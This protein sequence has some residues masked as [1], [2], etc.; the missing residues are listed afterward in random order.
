MTTTRHT[1]SMRREAQQAMPG[2]RLVTIPSAGHTVLVEQPQAGTAAITDL[3]R[4]V[5]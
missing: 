2:S 3:V 4:A 1:G 5:T